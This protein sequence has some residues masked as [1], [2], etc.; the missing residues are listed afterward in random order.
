MAGVAVTLTLT[1]S[2]LLTFC[3][4]LLSC[5]LS[6]NFLVSQTQFPNP[7]PNIHDKTPNSDLDL[8][9]PLNNHKL[10]L[11]PFTAENAD[12]VT[13]TPTYSQRA[14]TLAPRTEP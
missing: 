9:K 4:P 11:V 14:L 6:S 5:R 10:R 7:H 3:R 1:L 12:Q 2:P 8:W 13:P